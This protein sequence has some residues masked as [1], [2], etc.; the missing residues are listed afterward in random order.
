VVQ[1]EQGGTAVLKELAALPPREK[2]PNGFRLTALRDTILRALEMLGPPQGGDV[3][4]AITDGGDSKSR[5]SRKDLERALIRAQTRLFA[6]LFTTLRRRPIPWESD[7]AEDLWKIVRASGG[8]L[9]QVAVQEE[10]WMALPNTEMTALGKQVYQHMA[11]V[12]WMEIELGMPVDKP[13]DL[14]LELV[15]A[16]GKKKSPFVL[17][18]PRQLMPCAQP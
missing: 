2:Y 4:Y 5:K 13:R 17:A 15:P 16:P 10:G 12:T 3:I 14:K 7:G 1:L 9:S 18:Y 6:T 11:A 8:G